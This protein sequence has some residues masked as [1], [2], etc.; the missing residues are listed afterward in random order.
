MTPVPEM[1]PDLSGVT[2]YEVTHLMDPNMF[3]VSMDG[4]PNNMP[5]DAIV[6]VGM[7]I[8]TCDILFPDLFP[9]RVYCWG[10][11]PTSGTEVEIQVI[12]EEVPLPLL[13][14]S[15]RVPYPSDEGN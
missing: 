4:W 14:I 2:L 8:Y 5:E 9:Q 3:Q 7:E 1:I 15:F 6:R 13:E 11:A 12:L 10:R